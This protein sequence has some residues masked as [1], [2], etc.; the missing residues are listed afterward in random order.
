M[1]ILTRGV[2]GLSWAELGDRGWVTGGK[3]TI[4]ECSRYDEL[5]RAGLAE[6]GMK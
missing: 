2:D 4:I 3:L 6:L 1:T 5:G